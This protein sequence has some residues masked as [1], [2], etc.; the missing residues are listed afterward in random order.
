MAFFEVDVVVVVWAKAVVRPTKVANI[1]IRPSG[2][3]LRGK[4]GNR[5]E[6]KSR[7]VGDENGVVVQRRR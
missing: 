7:P 2:A 1:G 6:W 3:S 4:G 5:R